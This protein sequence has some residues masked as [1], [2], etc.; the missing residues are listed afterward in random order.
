MD[1]PGHM[2]KVAA[3]SIYGNNLKKSRSFSQV[4]LG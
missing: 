2:A 3:M 4:Q 1:G